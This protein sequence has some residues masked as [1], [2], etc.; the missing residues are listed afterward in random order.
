[1]T[2]SCDVI[3]LPCNLLCSYRD[4]LAIPKL[5]HVQCVK[6]GYTVV[7]GERGEA[8]LPVLK[9]NFRMESY[10]N[11]VFWCVGGKGQEGHS[12]PPSKMGYD[13]FKKKHRTVPTPLNFRMS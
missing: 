9:I 2:S 1:M 5:S 3:V 12:P 10:S 8:S 11:R 4:I 7:C 6:Y 13:H